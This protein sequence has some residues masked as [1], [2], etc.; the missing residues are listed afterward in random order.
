MLAMLT[1]RVEKKQQ[2]RLRNKN[3]AWFWFYWL[4]ITGAELC[5]GLISVKAG[6]LMHIALLIFLLLHAAMAYRHSF[7]R[8]YLPLCLAPLI[9]ILSLA[10]PLDEVA[11]VYRYVFIGAP[12]FAGTLIVIRLLGLKWGELGLKPGAWMLTAAL[13]MTGAPLGFIEYLILKP[14]PL[15]QA[16]AWPEII[17]P[18]LVLL[19]FTGF[20]EELIFRGVLYR[21]AVDVVGNRFGLFYSSFVFTSL[22]I[23]QL[24]WVDLLFVFIIA[25]FFAWM[26][27]RSRSIAGVSL[28]HGVINIGLY[29]LWPFFQADIYGAC[30]FL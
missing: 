20:L 6:L 25:V 7:G 8:L 12:L 4:A 1:G 2:K 27:G 3:I 26:A 21:V 5:T 22:H 11:M 13:G 23:I 15:I 9:R 24:S 18:A 29:L 28:A 19:I 16:P 30:D 17:V 14:R 10:L